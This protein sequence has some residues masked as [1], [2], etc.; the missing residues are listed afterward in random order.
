MT[1]SNIKPT[2]SFSRKE[3][4]T[5]IALLEKLYQNE[6]QNWRFFKERLEPVSKKTLASKRD[7]EYRIEIKSIEI[8]LHKFH[9]P[10][11]NNENGRPNFRKTLT[12]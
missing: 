7:R 12:A 9:S 10:L 2:F 6:F 8:L 3:R 11:I 4:E 1:K 5:L